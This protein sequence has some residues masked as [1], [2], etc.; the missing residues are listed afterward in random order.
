MKLT[1]AISTAIVGLVNTIMALLVSFD[2]ALSQGQQAS[3]I[4]VVNAL[5]IIAAAILDPTV[6]VGVKEESKKG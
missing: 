3:I 5:L 1:P 6:P 4:G 2:I